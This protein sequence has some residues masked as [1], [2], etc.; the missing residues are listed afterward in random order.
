MLRLSRILPAL[1][2]ASLPSLAA[3]ESDIRTM[4]LGPIAPGATPYVYVPFQVPPG[5]AE[6]TLHLDYDGANGDNAI[7]FG[8]FDSTFSGRPDDLTGY[9]GKNPNRP[10]LISVIGRTS[11]S[12]GHLPGPL[13]AGAWRVMFYVYKTQAAGVDVRLAISILHEGAAPP[14]TTPAW[15]L[16]DLHTHTLHSDGIWTLTSLAAA[17]QKAGLDFLAVTDHNVAS[18]HY[19]IDRMPAAGPLLIKGIEL[20]TYGGHM[21]VWGVP[22][23]Q[24]IEHRE[25]PGDNAALQAAVAQAHK[26]GALIS[27][28][29]PFG[30]CKACDWA[31]DKTVPNFDGIEVWN[32]AW[33]RDDQLA[34]NWWDSLLR[35]GRHITAIGSSDSHGPQNELGLPTL[36]LYAEKRS[37]TGILDAITHGRA[38][39]SASPPI[40][41]ELVA[42]AGSERAIP[43][44]ELAVTTASQPHL[45]VTL[46]GVTQ[47]AVVLYS[48]TGEFRRWPLTSAPFHQD[49]LV[50]AAPAYYRIEA[51]DA[52]GSM[53]AL[54]N[55]IWIR[56]R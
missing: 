28:N 50:P 19:E 39:I 52:N 3:V 32:G 41:V 49:L 14:A 46:Q 18:H 17:A 11:A 4:H 23:G 51:R 26:L 43:G 34:L 48:N 12:Y 5:A 10:P 54:T 44:E 1:L 13:P 9:R 7:D 27:V 40:Q 15:L 20:T 22:T 38:T 2:I 31:F 6:I 53:L 21:N 36:R 25:M 42:N 37:L 16:G 33:T 35:S 45:L 8:V 29:H 55:P 30:T 56:H 24:M 47:G